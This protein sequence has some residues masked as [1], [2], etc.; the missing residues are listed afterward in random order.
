MILTADL[1]STFLKAAL[2]DDTGRMYGRAVRVRL[3]DSASPLCWINSLDKACLSLQEQYPAFDLSCIM[4]TGNGPTVV[5]VSS[6]IPT[7]SIM[8]DAGSNGASSPAF[9]PK[10]RYLRDAFPQEFAKASLFLGSAEY[11]CFHLTGKACASLPPAGFEKYYWNTEILESEGLE[12][13]KFPPFMKPGTLLGNSRKFSCIKD[14]TPVLVPCPDY[15]PAI[16]GC[17]AVHDGILCL[18]TGTGDGLNL[19]SSS[20]VFPEGLMVSGHPNGKDS[21]LSVIIPDTGAA[22]E[23]ARME[24]GLENTDFEQS[25]QEGP[26]R[27]A[28]EKICLRTAQALKLYKDLS[29]KEIRIAHGLFDSPFLNSLR[30]RYTGL[31]VYS[32]DCEE[33]GLQGLAIMASSYLTGRDITLLADE[34]VELTPVLP[35]V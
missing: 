15:I 1:G 34:N 16:V 8:W 11:L 35:A 28:C 2:A 13:A 22:I 21:N 26:V 9:L 12:P 23:R 31:P 27:D 29:I 33:T 24:A 17:G 6:G 5:P 18:R 20:D 7:L 32:T 4:L 3:E 19:C 30:A 14:G 10:I 25:L